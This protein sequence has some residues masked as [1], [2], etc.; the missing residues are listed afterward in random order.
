MSREKFRKVNV[1][2]LCPYEPGKPIMEV[3][4][5]LGLEH[6]VKLASNENPLGPSPEVL[7]VLRDTDLFLSQ[8]P[9]INGHYLRTALSRVMDVPVDEII[10]GNGSADL[11][12]MVADAFL[13]PGYESM[14]PDPSFPV[15]QVVARIAGAEPINVPLD[16]RLR[17]DLHAMRRALSSRTRIIWLANPNNPTGLAMPWEPVERFLDELPEGVIT[18]IDLAYQH[19]V[20]LPGYH[21][22]I[23]RLRHRDRVIILETFSKAHGLAGLRCGVGVARKRHVDMMARVRMP[24]SVN[25]AAQVAAITSLKDQ[26]HIRRSVQLN[27][28]VMELYRSGLTDL[29]LGFHPSDANFILVRLPAGGDQVAQRL[30]RQGVIV[31]YLPHGGLEDTIRVTTGTMEQARF[32]LKALARIL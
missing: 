29:G 1:E 20:S 15:Y 2:M 23:S 26:A 22:G 8:Y 5:E 17:V 7:K 32:F 24:F 14:A 4:R 3:K 12:K 27:A 28:R 10:L 21:E 9:D 16:Q 25:S 6:V 13:A 31:R 30:L 11:M 18:V 19:Y